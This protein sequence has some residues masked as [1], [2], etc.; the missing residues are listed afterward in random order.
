MTMTREEHDTDAS[1][2]SNDEDHSPRTIALVEQLR[3]A[4]SVALGDL[5]ALGMPP[6]GSTGQLLLAALRTA[7]A[8][9]TQSEEK[10]P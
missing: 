7:Q 9:L 8:Y 3:H 5:L 4:C 1:N 10:T 2:A 6:K